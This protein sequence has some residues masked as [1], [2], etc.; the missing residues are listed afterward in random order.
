MKKYLALYIAP[1]GEIDKFMALPDDEKA[2]QMGADM[3][4]WTKWDADH[5][6]DIVDLG[7]P[8][9]K[10]KKITK[11]G[12]TDAKNELTGYTV[13]Q[14]ESYDDAVK[15]FDGHPHFNFPGSTIEIMELLSID[16]D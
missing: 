12:A 4:K 2:K 15:V 9:G 7:A 10:T 13:L 5:K 3:E 6:K 1:R 14:A 11:D 8:L 16:G